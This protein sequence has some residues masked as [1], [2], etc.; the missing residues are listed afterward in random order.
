[1]TEITYLDA[2][3]GAGY[4]PEGVRKQAARYLGNGTADRKD[5]K[6]I[7]SEARS[8]IYESFGIDSSRGVIFTKN[9]AEALR[10]AVRTFMGYGDLAMTTVMEHES[11]LGALMRLNKETDCLSR[12]YYFRSRTGWKTVTGFSCAEL[13][14]DHKPDYDSFRAA[15]LRKRPGLII[16]T[17][18]SPLTGDLTDLRMISDIAREIGAFFVIDASQ[19]AGLFNADITEAGADAVCFSGYKQIPGPRGIGALILGDPDQ[20]REKISKGHRVSVPEIP[21]PENEDYYFD[22]PAALAGFSAALMYLRLAGADTVRKHA[23]S[24]ARQFYEGVSAIPGVRLYGNYEDYRRAP[25]TAFTLDGISPEML[26]GTLLRRFG[27][28]TACGICGAPLHA[29]ALGIGRGGAVRVSFSNGST[30]E[31]AAYICRAVRE[32]RDENAE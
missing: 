30:E 9:A 5:V 11:V 14:P 21:D 12:N 29:E 2:A 31:Q 3:G 24:L 17:H 13:A 27:I 18:A 32:I 4:I 10:L 19:T 25:I 26:R 6:K 7:A 23:L 28:Y 20:I 15:A 22:D 16:C 8:L 1:M